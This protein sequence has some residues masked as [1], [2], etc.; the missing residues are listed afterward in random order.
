M[1]AFFRKTGARFEIIYLWISSDIVAHSLDIVGY[2]WRRRI[3]RISLDIV[4]YRWISLDIVGYAAIDCIIYQRICYD[5]TRYTTISMSKDTNSF[6]KRAS[7]MDHIVNVPDQTDT[8]DG[9]N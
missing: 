3:L 1:Q 9:L 7:M 6:L 2:R 5:L 4:G 8:G